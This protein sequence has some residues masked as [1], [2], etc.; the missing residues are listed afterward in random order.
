VSFEECTNCGTGQ[1]QHEQYWG[2]LCSIICDVELTTEERIIKL[3]ESKITCDWKQ[4]HCEACDQTDY[5]IALIKGSQNVGTE[6][7]NPSE[8][9][10][11]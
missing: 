8:R 2:C 10:N 4:E 7:D 3:L 5:L 9:E 1:L 6:I 11:K